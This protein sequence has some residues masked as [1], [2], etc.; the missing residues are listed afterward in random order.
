[1]FV[2]HRVRKGDTLS[3]IAKRYRTS[4]KAISSCNNIKSHRIIAG[5]VLKIPTKNYAAGSY[6]ASN[7]SK[8]KIPPGKSITYKV[9]RGDN[10]WLIAKKFS[11]TTKQIM[12]QNKLSGTNLRIGQRLTISSGKA[13]PRP[14][15]GSGTYKVRSGDSPFLI[16]KRHNMS[17]N[18]LLALNSLSKRSKIYPGQKLIVE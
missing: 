12:S 4:V 13:A 14:K 8:S 15:K 7:S 17:L 10:L 6:V 11:T 9:R 3:G 16:A 5:K 2:Y 1:M 18:R